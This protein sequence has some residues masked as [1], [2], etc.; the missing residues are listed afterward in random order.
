M[1][2]ASKKSN[3]ELRTANKT[4]LFQLRSWLFVK[5]NRSICLNKI[6]VRKEFLRNGLLSFEYKAVE[7]GLSG[8]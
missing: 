3:Y 5:I 1:S 6:I 7:N 8:L 4:S 2:S